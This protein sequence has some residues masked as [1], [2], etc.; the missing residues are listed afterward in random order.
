MAMFDVKGKSALITGGTSGI[1]LATAERLQSAG[2]RVV[3][4]GRRAGGAEIAERIGAKFPER[5][6]MPNPKRSSQ[7]TTYRRCRKRSL[8]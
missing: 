7:N 6:N 4:V 1:G 2:A 3:I 8:K 5:A